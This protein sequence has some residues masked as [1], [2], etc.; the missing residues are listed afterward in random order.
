MKKKR[1]QP[2]EYATIDFDE[3]NNNVETVAFPCW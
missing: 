1:H 3:R 2:L